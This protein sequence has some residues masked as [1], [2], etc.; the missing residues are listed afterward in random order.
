MAL[1]FESVLAVGCG[2]YVIYRALLQ[3]LPLKVGAKATSSSEADS[4]GRFLHS[5][6][7]LVHSHCSTN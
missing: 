7:R 5:G 2:A 6:L 1:N 4:R 3:V